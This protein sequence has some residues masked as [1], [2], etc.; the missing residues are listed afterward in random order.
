MNLFEILRRLKTEAPT[1]LTLEEEFYLQSIERRRDAGESL[2][3]I[4]IDEGLTP[5]TAQQ[6]TFDPEVT[7]YMRKLFR[8]A[9]S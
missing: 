3:R 1:R 8:K 6:F 7:E 5:E 4:L 9:A 2:A